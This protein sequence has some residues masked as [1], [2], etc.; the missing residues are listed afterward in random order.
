MKN[1]N[2]QTIIFLSVT[3]LLSNIGLATS[4]MTILSANEHIGYPIFGIAMMAISSILCIIYATCY[5]AVVFF[6]KS[7]EPNSN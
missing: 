2:R 6:K 4:S 5:L 3:L 7:D 1:K